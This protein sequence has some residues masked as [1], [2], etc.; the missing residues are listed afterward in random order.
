MEQRTIF[1]TGGLGFIGSNFVEHIFHRYP[2]YQILVLDALTYAGT[3]QNIPAEIW[4]SPRFEFWHGSVTN[5]DI[6]HQ[7]MSRSQFVVHFAAES[8]VARSIFDNS[9]FFETDV[10]GTQVI[11]N[12]VLKH[13][14]IERFIHISTSEVY[15]TALT[16]PMDENHPLEPHTPYAGAKAGAD[17]LVASYW[18]CYDIPA[19]ILRPFNNYGPKQ[20]LEKVIPRFITNALEDSKLRIHGDGSHT[21]DWTFVADT[22]EAIDKV[23][24]IADFARVR[25]QVINIG[26][27]VDQ[28]ILDIAHLILER[29]EKEKEL[30]THVGNRPGQVQRHVADTQKAEELLQWKAQT[31]FEDGL[32]KTIRWYQDN[33]QWWASM[34]YMKEVPIRTVDGSIEFH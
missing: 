12:S 6:V 22:C 16:V 33:P 21:R 26:S 24:H 5:P 10:L 27:G 1:I 7:L 19:V 20:H 4:E 17:R 2:E 31:G 15:G 32:E 14:N 23:L 29:L 25:N 18:H 3:L 11:T 28:G 34:R 8:H 9:K 30:V 13:K